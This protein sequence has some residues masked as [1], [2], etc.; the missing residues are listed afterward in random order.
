MDMLKEV[1]KNFSRIDDE[2]ADDQ[3]PNDEVDDLDL[4]DM[5]MDLDADTTPGDEPDDVAF[6]DQSDDL[7]L[8][9]EDPSNSNDPAADPIVDAGGI[10]S[11][12]G[13][14]SLSLDGDESNADDG[15]MD[16]IA[17]AVNDDP[18]RQGVIRTVKNAHLV[19]KRESGTGG[20]EEL[21]IYNVGTLKDELAVRKAILSGTDI[22]TNKTSSEDGSQS[23]TL[24]SAGNAELVH[25][26]GLQN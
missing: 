5:D 9:G 21:W 20:Y 13:G 14:D 10:G 12:D 23:Y 19:Y 24:W 25:I 22:P 11:S 8:D 16:N 2:P 26:T 17:D 6:D 15:S 4:D 7:E 1:I 3:L 18:N